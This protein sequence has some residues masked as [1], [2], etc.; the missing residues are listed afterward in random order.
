MP[1]DY[2]PDLEQLLQMLTEGQQKPTMP[3]M[4]MGPPQ[5]RQVGRLFVASNPLESLAYGLGQYK[6]QQGA[7][8]QQK[9]TGERR[10]MLLKAMGGADPQQ[11]AAVAAMLSGDP[12]MAAAGQHLLPKARAAG[13]R[14]APQ[15]WGALPG[16][17]AS[18]AVTSGY[19]KKP[20]GSMEPLEPELV[21]RANAL[22]V[23]TQGRKRE[24]V[25][26]DIL[27]A[28]R[29]ATERSVRGAEE[30]TKRRE[31]TGKVRM[32]LRKEFNNLPVVKKT[33]EVAE[34]SAKIQSTSPT[35][36]GDISLLV[37]YM[38][39]IDPGSTVRENEFATAENA[40]GVTSKV[41]NVYNKLLEGDKLPEEMRQQFRT[42][43][44][45]ILDAQLQNYE[46]TATH[47]QRFAEM[48]G[49]APED[50]VMDLGYRKKKETAKAPA[51]GTDKVAARRAL[52]ESMK[53]EGKSASEILAAIKTQGL[54]Q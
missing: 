46:A 30:E 51:G 44:Q 36:P 8:E 23:P 17:T 14:L 52:A 24:P 10:R 20:E 15:E 50:V 3:Q 12:A 47:Y 31:A 29:S 32:D 5:G 6:Q 45:R 13:D 11:R 22:K 18:E 37:A 54:A 38:K 33:Q 48:S 2:D 35:G 40:G 26:A 19:A 34:A 21:A 53:A 16:M 43:A 42:E 25:I 1:N 39:M 9:A 27:A 4:P 49:L 7:Q 28:E 41:R